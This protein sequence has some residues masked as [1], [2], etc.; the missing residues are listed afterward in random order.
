MERT[1]MQTAT[2]VPWRDFQ[3]LKEGRLCFLLYVKENSIANVHFIQKIMFANTE[4]AEK[5][6]EFVERNLR[7]Q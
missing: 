1:A 3:K 4:E 7:L 2:T 5:F 6:K